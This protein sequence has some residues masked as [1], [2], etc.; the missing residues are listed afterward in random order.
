[1]EKELTKMTDTFTDDLFVPDFVGAQ[2]I[3]FP[4]SRLVL[5]PERFLNDDQEIMSGLG[6]GVIYTRT[7]DG[8]RLR[9]SPAIEERMELINRYYRPHHRK[10]EDCVSA[11]LQNLGRC[12]IID[13]HSFPSIALQYELDQSEARPDIC[14][15]ADDFHTPDWIIDKLFGEFEK[16]GYSTAVNKPFSGAI[17]PLPYYKK[18]PKVLSVMIEVNRKLYMDELSGSRNSGYSKLKSNISIISSKLEP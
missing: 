7:S 3:I 6:M 5:D 4:V 18:E 17:V 11:C 1:M 16:F 2:T 10:L 13:C 12:M 9:N 15:G 8:Q 14:I